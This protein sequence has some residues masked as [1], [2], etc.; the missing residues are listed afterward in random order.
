MEMVT[1][2]L[3]ILSLIIVIAIDTTQKRRRFLVEGK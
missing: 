3:M 1:L 2:G